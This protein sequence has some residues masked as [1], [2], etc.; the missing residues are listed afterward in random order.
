VFG[1]GGGELDGGAIGGVVGG[2]AGGTTSVD[3]TE[4]LVPVTE[5]MRT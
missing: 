1:G 2:V 3:S 4:T 5:T